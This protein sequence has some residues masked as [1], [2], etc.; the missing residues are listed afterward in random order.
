MSFTVLLTDGTSVPYLNAGYTY[1][2][3][4]G[5]KLVVEVTDPGGGDGRTV[6]TYAA[7]DWSRVDGPKL[8]ALD[9]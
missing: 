8:E 9:V 7:A 4:P 1:R 3:D 2:V 5:R 6:A